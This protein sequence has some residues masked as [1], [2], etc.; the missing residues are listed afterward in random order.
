MPKQRQPRKSDFYTM[1]NTIDYAEIT[2]WRRFED[3]VA[4]Y[5]RQDKAVKSVDAS[6]EGVDGGRDVLVTFE[7]TDSVVTFERK[8]V[9]QCKFFQRSVSPSDIAEVNIPT[10]VHSYNANGYLLVCRTGVTS[11]V[12][13]M[14]ECLRKECKMRYDYMTW[15]GNMFETKLNMMPYEPLIQQYFPD[16]YEFLK[17]RDRTENI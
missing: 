8:W 12:S 11:G 15:T 3:L 1:R 17:A 10:L 13:L 4:D 9:V 2:D 5:F 7:V 14:F 6:G 16:Y